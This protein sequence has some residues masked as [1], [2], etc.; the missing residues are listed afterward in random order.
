M[1]ERQALFAE[2]PVVFELPVLVDNAQE[3]M[4][5]EMELMGF[6][7][8]DVFEMVDDEVGRYPLAGELRGMLGKEVTVL[9]YLVCT[10]ET[11]TKEKRELMH[12]GTFL[13][14]GGDWLDTVHFPEAARKWPFEGRGFYRVRGRVMEEFGVVSVVVE[15]MGKVGVKRVVE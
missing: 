10:K 4:M 14:A 8:G 2:E 12:F 5:K 7:V 11:V 6:P 13:D 9:G 3:D 1:P 15:E